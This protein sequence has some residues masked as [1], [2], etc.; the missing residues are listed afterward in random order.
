MKYLRTSTSIHSNRYVY[1]LSHPLTAE[2]GCTADGLCTIG[3]WLAWCNLPLRQA[4]YMKVVMPVE[5]LE[6]A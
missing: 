5:T 1:G 4:Q 3:H 2:G 6:Y